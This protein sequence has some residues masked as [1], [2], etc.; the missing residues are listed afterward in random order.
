M[1]EVVVSTNMLQELLLLRIHSDQVR[2]REEN[3][4]IILTP[5]SDLQSSPM[6]ALEELRTML[7]DGRMSSESFMA[8]KQIDKELER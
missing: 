6:N 4:V 1:N 2:V 7:S 5:V 3:G 8:R